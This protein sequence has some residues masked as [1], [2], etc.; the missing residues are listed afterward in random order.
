MV[1]WPLLG[2][3]AMMG[4]RANIPLNVLLTIPMFL[5][6]YLLCRFMVLR[7]ALIQVFKGF[8]KFNMNLRMQKQEQL[9]LLIKYQWI[10]HLF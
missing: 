10:F 2:E 9:L 3:S 8:F 5:R 1:D 6:L 7:S 4:L